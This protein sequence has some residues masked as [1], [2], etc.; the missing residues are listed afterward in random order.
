MWKKN[1]ERWQGGRGI[2]ECEA[3]LCK[4]IWRSHWVYLHLHF[5]KRIS[6]T[7]NRKS[8]EIYFCLFMLISCSAIG[9]ALFRGGDCVRTSHRTKIRWKV[10]SQSCAISNSQGFVEPLPR[11]GGKASLATL[12]SPLVWG[13]CREQ[14]QTSIRFLR[15]FFVGTYWFW[16]ARLGFLPA[17]RKL[18]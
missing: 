10:N 8:L 11:W 12:L 16:V 4:I 3:P 18:L 9:M 14:W 6:K 17:L 1:N 2:L 13:M 7:F 15:I 5:M